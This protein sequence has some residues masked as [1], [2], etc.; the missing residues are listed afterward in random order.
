MMEN[1][2]KAMEKRAGEL[3]NRVID[4]SQ[5]KGW[6]I[7]ADPEND[8]TYPMKHRAAGEHDGYTW[9]RPAQQQTDVEVLHSN[10]RPNVSAVFG[11]STPPSGV[12]GM[13][14]RAAFHYSEN[15][16]GHWLPLMVADRIGVVEGLAGDLASGRVPNIFGE[17][18]WKAEW[19]HNRARLVTRVL[20]VAAVAS[21]AVALLRRR[22]G[23]AQMELPDGDVRRRRRLPD[24]ND[25]LPPG[26]SEDK[27][28][29]PRR[30]NPFSD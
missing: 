16:Y 6:G 5:V 10:E 7:D 9:E 1:A 28:T 18:G 20:V 29:A 15:S 17:L 23:A 11:T 24:E 4:P 3:E 27:N 19:R 21:A 30:N 26:P 2:A 12:S 22:K 25:D 14:R 8:P 13:I